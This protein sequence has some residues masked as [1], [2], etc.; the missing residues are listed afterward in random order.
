MG[1][2]DWLHQVPQLEEEVRALFIRYNFQEY[3][4]LTEEIHALFER[5][6]VSIR[7]SLPSVHRL[8]KRFE[9]RQNALR[10]LRE[11][12]KAANAET[13]D[14]A[15]D[16]NDYILRLILLKGYEFLDVAQLK[17]GPVAVKDYAAF[18]RMLSDISRAQTDVKRL[19]DAQRQQ[20]EQAAQD[21]DE[22]LQA[23]GAALAERLDNVLAPHLSRLSETRRKAI[24]ADVL[25]TV[26]AKDG[27]YHV[28]TDDYAAQIREKILGIAQ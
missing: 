25:E 24:T 4:E 17:D 21:V 8:G 23:A 12:A 1:A 20:A 7:P 27:S 3:R 15:A 22:R 6:G 5:E 28:L 14:D 19:R 26:Q 13:G 18:G 2:R 16:I 11:E 9:A 10:D